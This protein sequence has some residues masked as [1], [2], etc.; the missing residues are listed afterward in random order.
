MNRLIITKALVYL[1]L[2]L[3]LS[4]CGTI[5]S[6]NLSSPD[7]KEGPIAARELYFR[8]QNYD[9]DN[10]SES[11]QIPYVYSGVKK[12]YLQIMKPRYCGW[13]HGEVGPLND[14]I[15][16]ITIP[17]YVVDLPL[18]FVADTV[19]LPWAIP[20]QRKEGNL[21]DPPYFK[22]GN[23]QRQLRNMDKAKEYYDKGFN[24][25]PKYYGALPYHEIYHYLP[26][27]EDIL[28]IYATDYD[29]K[30]EY[31]KAVLYYENLVEIAVRYQNGP[32]GPVKRRYIDLG[33]IYS[34]VGN[35]DKA[36]EC[37]KKAA[38]YN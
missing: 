12:D 9:C 31:D 22:L 20:R 29:Q 25:L 10:P 17:I 38:E 36:A 18:S 30:S 19:M 21:I 16:I 28:L 7:N 8:F 32:S 3:I 11:L 35:N 4:S 5:T 27:F 26:D 14:L 33:R 23:M 24:V 15:Y 37:Y 2:A 34:K 13:S 6:W 1:F